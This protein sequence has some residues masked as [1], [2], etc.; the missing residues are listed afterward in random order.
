MT[1]TLT[2]RTRESAILTRAIKPRG[3]TLSPMVAKA[4][5]AMQLDENDR[6]RLHELAKLNQAGKLSED[7]SQELQSYL[8]VGML[9][10]LLQAKARLS[11][12]KTTTS[13]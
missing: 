3:K 1:I 12:K 5:L 13:R 9:L 7:Q 8:N 10:D 4:L 11:I 2:P 6:V